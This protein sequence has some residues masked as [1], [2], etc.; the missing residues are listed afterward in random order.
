M[1]IDMNI[2]RYNIFILISTFARNIIE[3][4]SSVILYKMGYTL[5]E[6]FIFYFTFYLSGI[7]VSFTTINLT[8]K[9][10]IKYLLIISSIIFSISFYYISV[11]DKIFIN[12][13]IF[14]FLYSIG[15]FSYHSLRHYL[16]ISSLDNNKKNDIGNIVIYMNIALIISSLVSGYLNSMLSNIIISIILIVLSLISIIPL[17]RLNLDKK[18]NIIKYDKIDKNRIL[19]FIFEQGKVLFLLFEPLYIY[20]YVMDNIKYV[21]ITSSLTLISSLIFIYFF[22]R[23]IDD[24]KCFKYLN[25]I[26]CLILFFKIN[27][28]N[29]YLMLFIV[30]LEGLGIKMYEVVSMENMYNISHS[31]NIKGYLIITESIFCLVRA[32]LSFIFIYIDNLKIILYLLITLILISGFIKRRKML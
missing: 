4:L 27:I 17:L 28:S 6:I 20:L 2:K 16:G 23:K 15:T 22:V 30:F 5:K 31:T 32:I 24:R 14:S 1:V 13:I 10:K 29:K 21:G 26:L 7:V 9:I 25:I 8:K 11:M 19:F 3:V 12:L 18:N